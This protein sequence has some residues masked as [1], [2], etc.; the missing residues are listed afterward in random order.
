MHSSCFNFLYTI[1]EKTILERFCYLGGLV[2]QKSPRR[3]K[4]ILL[5]GELPPAKIWHLPKHR[6]SAKQSGRLQK[7]LFW[8]GIHLWW[9]CK[10]LTHQSLP[11]QVP[12]EKRSNN[13]C[14]EVE[15]LCSGIADYQCSDVSLLCWPGEVKYILANRY[16][17]SLFCRKST[18]L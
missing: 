13:R 18:I 2:P 14:Q 1:V 7:Q 3:Y 4:V 16:R 8:P 9:M 6:E 11:W 15:V 10:E 5:H 12:L 17:G